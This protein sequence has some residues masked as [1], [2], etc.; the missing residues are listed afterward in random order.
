MSSF[1][2]VNTTLAAPEGSS[3]SGKGLEETTPTT[4]RPNA[5]FSDQPPKEI[6]REESVPST[7]TRHNFG[8]VPG[9]R[10]LP[11]APFTPSHGADAQSELGSGLTRE[12]S[13]RSVHS[14]Q[15][16]D[17]QDVDMADDDDGQEASDNESVT[18]DSQR[19]SKKKKKGQRFFCT[20]FPPCTLSF[21]RSEHLARHIRQVHVVSQALQCADLY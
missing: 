16:S 6:P 11:S 10:P 14:H 17:S 21:T 19:P 5:R 1:R 12:N 13:H 4:P 2:P 7:P 3:G 20:D 9:Q 18:S 8:G 15:S